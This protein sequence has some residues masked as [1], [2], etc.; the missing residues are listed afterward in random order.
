MERYLDMER[1]PLVHPT[2]EMEVDA[3][4]EDTISRGSTD[5]DETGPKDKP[6]KGKKGKGGVAKSFGSL[7]K[8]MKNLT[9]MGKEGK[10]GK[11]EGKA[12]QRRRS[13]V[14]SA[15]QSTKTSS[16]TVEMIR[17]RSHILCVRLSPKRP[18]YQNEMVHNYL[19]DAHERFK[20]D[21]NLRSAQDAEIRQRMSVMRQ[22]SNCINQGCEQTATA[23]TSYLCPACY[24]KEK[25]QALEFE[26]RPHSPS[27]Q[28][29]VPMARNDTLLNLGKSRFYTLSAEDHS[30]MKS[31]SNPNLSLN[32]AS[33]NRATYCESDYR[34]QPP[35]QVEDPRLSYPLPPGA[36]YIS[37]KLRDGGKYDTLPSRLPSQKDTK[38][39]EVDGAAPTRQ[40]AFK[41]R[42]D[43][44]VTAK[45]QQ[46]ASRGPLK[47]QPC[48][49]VACQFYGTEATD[50]LC[51][52]CYKE[53]K[54]RQ[55]FVTAKAGHR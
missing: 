18:E 20:A 23:A 1:L 45:I 43:D 14:G 38:S 27:A 41:V 15:T 10:T 13:S 54:T 52:S 47:Q 28:V 2:A 9:K 19:L 31:N 29:S 8:K 46:E 40:T 42:L 48:R 33:D 32:N 11:E 5:S 6:D 55:A 22:L 36:N 4:P 25:Q 49:G 26:N 39:C 37:N 34:T 16:I 44:D 35:V 3:R 17:Q 24:Q 7:G 51:S 12:R 30:A 53:S 21:R 50:Y